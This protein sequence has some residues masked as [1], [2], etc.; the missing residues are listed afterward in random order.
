MLFED[1]SFGMEDTDRV[2]IIG[3]NGAG[4]T[5]FLKVI[6]GVEPPDTGIVAFNKEARFEYLQQLPHFEKHITVL[7]A[8][9]SGKPHLAAA[10]ARHEDLCAKPTLTQAEE[11]ELHKVN[12]LIDEKHG[13]NLDSEAKSMLSRLG[14]ELFDADVMNLSGGQRKRV[15]LARALLSEPDLLILDEPTNHLDAG[16]VQW[17]Q[18][19]L[20]QAQ[21]GLLLVTHDRYFLD[22]VCNRIIELDRNKL[23]NYPGNFERYLER[24]EAMIEAEEAAAEHLRNKLRQELAWLQRGAKARRTKQQSRIDWIAKMQAEPPPPD[25]KNIKIEL[26]NVF[27]GGRIIDAYNIGKNI[28]DRVLFQNFTYSA[29]P[30]DKIGIIGPNGTGKSTLLNTLAGLIQP[31]FGS[32]KL[33][34]TVK[35]GYFKQEITDLAPRQTVIGALR[36]IAEY[37]DVGVGRE[38]YLTAKELLDRF[39]F[40]SRQQNSLIETLSGGERR[41]LALLRVLMA[42]PNVLMLDEPT[43]DFD[44]ATLGALEEHLSHFKGV[45]LIVSHDRSFLDKTVD[46]VYA[47]EEGGII[48]QYPG[49]YSAYLEKI[50]QKKETERQNKPTTTLKEEPIKKDKP[51]KAGLSFKEQKEYEELEKNIERWEKEKEQVSVLMTKTDGSDYKRI[52]E[53]SEQLATIE[54]NIDTATERWLELEER[55]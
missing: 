12:R 17:L 42:N 53:L 15:A 27:L 33:G 28:G 21:K 47:L 30:G 37:I 7:E 41:R 48:K 55:K 31:D 44:I 8:A 13:W 16:S 35:I 52:V 2:G 36:E 1:V 10:L 46:F 14:M 20:Q 5:T 22:A 11:E 6:A 4:K 32:V 49:N 18:D 54:Q 50:E 45:L 39:L 9:M 25:E 34:E 23:F 40:P 19:Y 43:N 26:G 51:K 24:K 29:A 38:R 3:R